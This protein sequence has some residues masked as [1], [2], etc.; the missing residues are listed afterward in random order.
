MPRKSAAKPVAKCSEKVLTWDFD[1][2]PFSPQ[3]LMHLL[4]ALDAA[5]TFEIIFRDTRYDNKLIMDYVRKLRDG[6]HIPTEDIVKLMVLLRNYMLKDNELE[7]TLSDCLIGSVPTL[8]DAGASMDAMCAAQAAGLVKFL[9][10]DG[11]QFRA[12]AEAPSA[13][14]DAPSGKK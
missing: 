5:R 6:K 11:R 10:E 1:E 12:A 2:T 7:K 8:I 3:V 9:G 14:A 4:I 13:A